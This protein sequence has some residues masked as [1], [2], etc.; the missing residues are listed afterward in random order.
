MTIKRPVS[1]LALTMAVAL[2]AS[3]VPAKPAKEQT[4]SVDRAPTKIDSPNMATSVRDWH[5]ELGAV[6]TRAAPT[7]SC[8]CGK[9]NTKTATTAIAPGGK[10]VTQTVTNTGPT[11]QRGTRG[12]RSA[13][14]L[15]RAREVP[16]SSLRP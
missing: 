8:T 16:L 5:P 3:P 14:P 15:E 6:A 7:T 13:K 12:K 4:K 10:T 2:V 9:N 1:V 11:G